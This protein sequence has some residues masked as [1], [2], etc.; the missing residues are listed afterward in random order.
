MRRSLGQRALQ[1]ILARTPITGQHVRQPK[2]L[3]GPGCDKLPEVLP[4]P[5]V[6]WPSPALAPLRRSAS[7]QLCRYRQDHGFHPRSSYHGHRQPDDLDRRS[8]LREPALTGMSASSK[9]VSARRVSS[10]AATAGTLVTQVADQSDD[11]HRRVGV[12]V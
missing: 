7:A 10:G 6:H 12:V 1:Q 5:L 4:G 11:M 2:Q 9:V 3:G 8:S